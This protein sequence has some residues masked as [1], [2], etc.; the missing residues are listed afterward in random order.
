MDLYADS[1]WVCVQVH[2]RV[3][4]MERLNQPDFRLAESLRVWCDG[5]GCTAHCH[6]VENLVAPDVVMYVNAI[7]WVTDFA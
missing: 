7:I 1:Y 3:K 2:M 4:L 5:A 6:R